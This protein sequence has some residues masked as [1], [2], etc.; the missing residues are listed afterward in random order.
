MVKASLVDGLRRRQ[1]P[2]PKSSPGSQE[3][4]SVNGGVEATDL[5]TVAALKAWNRLAACVR[6][7]LGNPASSTPHSSPSI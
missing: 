3:R 1:K 2:D 4:R 5:K 7:K 6:A